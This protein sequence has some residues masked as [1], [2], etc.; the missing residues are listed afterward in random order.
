[1]LRINSC[2]ALKPVPVILDTYGT[3]VTLTETV[4]ASWPG[5]PPSMFASATAKTIGIRGCKDWKL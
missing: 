1:M 5:I 4:K 3:A 2:K